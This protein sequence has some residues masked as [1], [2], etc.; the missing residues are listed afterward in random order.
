MRYD[1]TADA[2]YDLQ[3]FSSWTLNTTTYLWEAPIAYPDD[4]NHY[5]W[6]EH[7]YW[8]VKYKYIDNV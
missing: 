5:T 8:L 6:N 4:D 7:Y 1:S 2:F 3:P